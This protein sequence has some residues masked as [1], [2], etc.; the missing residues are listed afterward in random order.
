MFQVTSN[1]KYLRII[2]EIIVAMSEFFLNNLKKEREYNRLSIRN[3]I[4][5]KTTLF[6]EPFIICTAQIL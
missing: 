4:T 5:I 3:L 6:R 2:N 1:I